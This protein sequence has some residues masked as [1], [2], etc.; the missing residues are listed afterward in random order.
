[1]WSDLGA[2]S[3]EL[4]VDSGN[5]VDLIARKYEV[6]LT[7]PEG[8]ILFFRDTMDSFCKYRYLVK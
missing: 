3:G 6:N 2:V 4:A 1:M 7:R 8:K 5:I